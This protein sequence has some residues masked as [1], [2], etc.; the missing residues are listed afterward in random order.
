[1]GPSKKPRIYA[2]PWFL[3]LEDYAFALSAGS[4]ST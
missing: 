3:I 4:T 2:G 1:M